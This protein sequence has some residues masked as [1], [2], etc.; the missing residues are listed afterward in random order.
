MNLDIQKYILNTL[1]SGNTIASN[2]PG[3]PN[4][5]TENDVAE[6][7]EWLNSQGFIVAH[8]Q[9]ISPTQHVAQ[10]RAMLLSGDNLR[11]TWH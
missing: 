4:D 8:F 3:H 9:S 5:Y 7:I 2:S 10:A 11:N 1:A 6:G